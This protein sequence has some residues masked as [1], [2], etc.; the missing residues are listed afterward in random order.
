MGKDPFEKLKILKKELIKKQKEE[1]YKSFTQK[2]IEP[3]PEKIIKK[4][5]SDPWKDEIKDVK[6]IKSA[7][8][9]TKESLTFEQL[10]HIVDEEQEAMT[11]LDDLVEGN[12]PFDVSDSDEF[13][14]GYV[15]GL[16]KRIIKKLRKGEFVF[17]KYIDLHR[18]KREEAKEKLKNFLHQS[19]Q[20]GVRSILVIHGRGLHSKDK[21]PVLKQLI[22]NWLIRGSLRKI[23]LAF[24]SAR[25]CDGGTGAI[26]ILLRK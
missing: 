8:I 18:L 14:E 22:V 26:Y 19:K 15:K 3:A 10:L 9:V 4:K 17:E 25:P 5:P 21:I 20:M 16:D 7:N 6:P 2:K 11:Y 13:I 24:T 12:V 1:K 23:I